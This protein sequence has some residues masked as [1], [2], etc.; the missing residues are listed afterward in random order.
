MKLVLLGDSITQSYKDLVEQ[1]A[2]DENE[3]WAP[4]ENCGHSLMHREKLYMWYIAPKPDVIHFNCGMWDSAKLADGVS[5]FSVNTYAYNLRLLVKR[6][7]QATDAKLI[8][9]T[10]TPILIPKDDTPPEMCS[11]DTT[12]I[13]YNDTARE[14][15]EEND[16]E[17]NDLFQAIMDNGFHECISQDKLHMTDQGNGVL[18][19]AV[20]NAA[21]G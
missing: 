19:D 11:V 7:R 12:V 18:A 13:K 4:D 6:V 21:L 5:R 3:V 16:V 10:T 15:M 20:V 17:V 8:F 9:G 2:G 1:K 14:V